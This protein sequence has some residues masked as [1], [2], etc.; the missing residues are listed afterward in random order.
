MMKADGLEN[1]TEE[2]NNDRYEMV[3]LAM[4]TCNQ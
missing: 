1:G 3:E 2:L 4:H